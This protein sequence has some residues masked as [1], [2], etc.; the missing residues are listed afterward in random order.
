[1]FFP[2]AALGRLLAA[3]PTL[4]DELG[5]DWDAHRA[6]VEGELQAADAEGE[7]LEVEVAT[8]ALLAA[9]LADDGS[10]ADPDPGPRLAWPPG[11]NDPCWCG[12]GVKYK[13]CCLPRGRERGGV[14]PTP[15]PVPAPAPAPARRPGPASSERVLP[16]RPGGRTRAR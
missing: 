1:M 10:D 4:A 14:G 12:S 8:P 3:Q 15:V 13:K 2:E 11:R 16:R 6:M 9:M 7:V 5:R